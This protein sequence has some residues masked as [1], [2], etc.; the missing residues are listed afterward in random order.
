MM[1]MG[2][3]ALVI[4]GRF[5]DTASGFWIALPDTAVLSRNGWRVPSRARNW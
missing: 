4:G 1:L 5:Q 3:V 2:S